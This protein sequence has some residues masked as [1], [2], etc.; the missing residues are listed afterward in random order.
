MEDGG[1]L[2]RQRSRAHPVVS[3]GRLPA[4]QVHHPRKR[5]AGDSNASA[6]QR[7]AAFGAVPAPWQVHS[8]RRMENSN[9]SALRRPHGFQPRP[10]PCPVHPPERRAEQSKP[11]PPARGCALVSSEARALP[12]SLSIGCPRSP[13]ASWAATGAARGW[14]AG[15]APGRAT[16]STAPSCHVRGNT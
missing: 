4:R 3:S 10:E 5:R 13:P 11:T 9:P 8:P 6:S 1:R 14:P 15:T 7:P 12:G 2:E 16:G